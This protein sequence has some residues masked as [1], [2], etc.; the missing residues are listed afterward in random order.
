MSRIVPF[1]PR[2]FMLTIHWLTLSSVGAKLD[3]CEDCAQFWAS[4]PGSPSRKKVAM[5]KW[6]RAMIS[7]DCQASCCAVGMGIPATAAVDVGA[8]SPSSA[9]ARVA[10]ARSAAIVNECG[11]GRPRAL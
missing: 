11:I 6:I 2:C 10:A 1:T 9:T 7:L 5:L 3:G 8:S 4:Q